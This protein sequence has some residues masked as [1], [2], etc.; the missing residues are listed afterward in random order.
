[1][2]IDPE[3]PSG[4]STILITMSRVV[5]ANEVK[6]NLQVRVGDAWPTPNTITEQGDNYVITYTPANV[7]VT[8][9]KDGSNVITCTPASG[10]TVQEII[11]GAHP[12]IYYRTVGSSKY[13]CN[14][15]GL[16]CVDTTTS[17]KFVI[18]FVDDTIGWMKMMVPDV[19]SLIEQCGG[20]VEVDINETS[21]GFFTV[22]C[23]YVEAQFFNGQPEPPLAEWNGTTPPTPVLEQTLM[24]R[25]SGISSRYL[26]NEEGRL[27]SD[28][29]HV[30]REDRE[31]DPL[32]PL[33]TGRYFPVELDPAIL[34]PLINNWG[35]LVLVLYRAQAYNNY[36]IT[37]GTY[38][39]YP[40]LYDFR[41]GVPQFELNEYR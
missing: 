13:L 16:L 40:K 9:P 34:T 38:A 26:V 24:Y 2:D 33:H 23:Y 25:D 41:Q 15:Y 37:Y 28:G 17:D 27:I 10:Q 8:V 39:G 20:S 32:D 30:F 31:G 3:L 14:E 35:D 6:D 11:W 1:M 7:T 36:E 12:A 5:T 4:S 21:M 19:E 18:R 29:T 22:T